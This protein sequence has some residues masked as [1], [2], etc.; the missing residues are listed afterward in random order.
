MNDNKKK[1]EKEVKRLKLRFDKIDIKDKDTNENNSTNEKK[2]ETD[3]FQCEIGD[4]NTIKASP[5]S[6][7]QLQVFLLPPTSLHV[8]PQFPRQQSQHQ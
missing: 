3:F 1:L 6:S 4:D 8:L 7:L 5:K 2:T